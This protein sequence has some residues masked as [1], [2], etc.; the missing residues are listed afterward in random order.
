MGEQTKLGD[1]PNRGE[2]ETGDQHKLE[3]E[4]DGD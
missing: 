1:K 2:T 4:R 3:T